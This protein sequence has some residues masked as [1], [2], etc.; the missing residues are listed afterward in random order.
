MPHHGDQRLIKLISDLKNPDINITIIGTEKNRIFRLS[1]G[2][3]SG[4]QERIVRS[5]EL[6]DYYKGPEADRDFRRGGSV[7]IF[8]KD[9][10]GTDTYI[11]IKEVEIIDGNEIIKCLSCHMFGMHN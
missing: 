7:Y 4:D 3:T 10:R 2:I 8:R 6:N 11:K 9:Y 1:L 5:L